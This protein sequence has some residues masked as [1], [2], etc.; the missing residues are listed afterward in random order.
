M[1]GGARAC[2]FPATAGKR[3]SHFRKSE[4]LSGNGPGA[5]LPAQDKMCTLMGI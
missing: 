5:G 3:A 4:K 1:E 2:F